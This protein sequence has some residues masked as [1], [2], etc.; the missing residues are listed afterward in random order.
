MKF[1]DFLNNLAKKAGKE[2]DPALVAI[3]SSSEL[4]NREIDDEFANHVDN[5]LMSLDGA[6]NNASLLNHFKP[7]VLKA[8]DDQYAI[9]SEELGIADVVGAEKSTYK[10]LD[11]LKSKYSS[12][13]T[14]LKEKKGKGNDNEAQLTEQI[15]QLQGQLSKLTEQSKTE[16]DGL[17]NAHSNEMNDMLVKF[18]LTGKKYAMKDVPVDVNVLTAKN[19]LQAELK[20]ASAVIVNDNGVLKLKQESNP[21]LD[22][23]DST[24]KN[25]SFDDFTN[26]VL[27]NNKLLEVSGGGK[28]NPPATQPPTPTT[29]PGG[30]QNNMSKFNEAMAASLEDAK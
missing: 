3:L 24:H 22:Y 10:K 11:L 29:I 27:A 20:K 15:K 14:E 9:L 5:N 7:I 16:L 8:L 23:Y 19:L 1:G 13:I 2:N 30:Q 6:K 17:K 26:Q 28:D 21:T 12:M 25:I 4:A 18:A